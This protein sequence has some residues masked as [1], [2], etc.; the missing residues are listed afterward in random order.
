MSKR[1]LIFGGTGLVGRYLVRKVLNKLFIARPVYYTR[2]I[3]K[4]AWN[5][6]CPWVDY[7]KYRLRFRPNLSCV[8]PIQASSHVL[9]VAGRGMNII[10]SQMWTYMSLAFMRQGYLPAVLLWRKQHLLRAYFHLCNARVFY[11]DDIIDESL[12]PFD[13]VQFAKCRTVEE[14]ESLYYRNMPVGQMVMSTYCRY[15]AT[16]FIDPQSEA[17]QAFAKEWVQ[18]ICRAYDAAQ[19]LYKD[20]HITAAVFSETFIEE[21][22]G[23]YYAGIESGVDVIKTSGTVRDNAIVVQ[24]RTPTNNRLHHAALTDPA[25]EIVK[26]LDN[27]PHIKASVEKNFEDRY[28]N[29]WFRSARNHQNTKITSREEGRKSLGISDNR[30]VVVVFSHILYDALFHYGDELFQDYATWLIETVRIA[31]QNPNVD[32]YI[33]LH[34]SNLWRGE[35]HSVLGGK[36]EEEKIID[37]FVGE[38]KSHVKLVYADT[39]ISPFGWYQIADYGISVRGTAGLEMACLGK[40]VI[41]A[42]TGRYEG[43]G[44][45]VDPKSIE[46]YTNILLNLPATPAL[47]AEQTQLANRYAHGLFNMKPFTLS[48]L[49]VHITFGKKKVLASD[50]IAYI[51][52]RMATNA[53]LPADFRRFAAYIADKKQLDLLTDET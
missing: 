44:F 4:T 24:R 34:P 18:G 27:Y 53:Q 16:G 48:G 15:H 26:K 3:L 14:W 13:T 49:E 22:G 43:K 35:F 2:K 47:T 19:K 39:A 51:P 38:L 46:D 21:Y 8:E 1:A 36:Y 45:T 41:T 5:R 50:D 31:N 6:F 42:G 17:M 9:F 20:E 29:K 12:Q 7:C 52:A 11:L 32:W 33:K 37:R 30:K 23:F 28:G 10:W 25:W 40:P